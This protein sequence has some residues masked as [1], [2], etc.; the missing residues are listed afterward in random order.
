MDA[1]SNQLSGLR[2]AKPRPVLDPLRRR[3]VLV[4]A[5]PL[6]TARGGSASEQW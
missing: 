6:S 1:E 4:A 2:G 5:L 3:L